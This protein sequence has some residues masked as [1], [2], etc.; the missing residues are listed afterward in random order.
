MRHVRGRVSKGSWIAD[1][2][3]QIEVNS[4]VW[5]AAIA[6]DMISLYSLL[7]A[8]ATDTSLLLG[9]IHPTRFLEPHLTL[10]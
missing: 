9:N 4:S 10:Q 8:C 2:H 1:A 5:Y 7:I 3:S 6:L